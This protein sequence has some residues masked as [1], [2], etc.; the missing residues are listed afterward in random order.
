M[1]QALGASLRDWQKRF[2]QAIFEGN[3]PNLVDDFYHPDAAFIGSDGH[4]SVGYQ[5]IINVWMNILPAVRGRKLEARYDWYAA[6][7]DGKRVFLKETHWPVEDA[8][9]TSLVLLELVRTDDNNYQIYRDYFN[10]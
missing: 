10:P 4:V 5:D 7:E 2:Y 1:S 3:A 6:A 8:T 9:K